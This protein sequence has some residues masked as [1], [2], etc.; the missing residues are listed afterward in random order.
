[1][2]FTNDETAENHIKMEIAARV[3]EER[4]RIGMKQSELAEFCVAAIGRGGVNSLVAYETGKQTPG[5]LILAAFLKAGMDVTYIL[6]GVRTVIAQ[7]LS[8]TEAALIDNYRHSTDTGKKAITQTALAL[9]EPYAE[10][11]V[12]KSA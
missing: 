9:A 4:L 8:Q 3:K 10:Y 12:K 2:G 1:M 5:G 11:T 6:T 7:P